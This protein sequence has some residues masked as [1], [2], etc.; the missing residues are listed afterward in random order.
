M[1]PR[2]AN[3]VSREQRVEIRDKVQRVVDLLGSPEVAVDE[4]HGP[5]LYSSFLKSLL[6]SPGAQIDRPPPTQ[7]RLM[8]KSK[9]VSPTIQKSNLQEDVR[10]LKQTA[11]STPVTPALIRQSVSPE[12]ESKS[13]LPGVYSATSP[14]ASDLLPPSGLGMDVSESLFFSPPLPYDPELLQTMTDPNI[15]PEVAM[16]GTFSPSSWSTLLILIEY[17]RFRLDGR[18]PTRQ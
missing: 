12:P 2:Y 13:I 1:Q 6:D 15:W 3:Y 17:F 11:S 14:E 4:R 18:L 5:K 16:P 10:M 8:A 9:S 7:R